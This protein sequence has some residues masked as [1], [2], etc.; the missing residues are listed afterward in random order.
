ML[1]NPAEQ[2]LHDLFRSTRGDSGLLHSG[3]RI[4]QRHSQVEECLDGGMSRHIHRLGP[5]QDRSD[6]SSAHRLSNEAE[7]AILLQKSDVA[8][9]EAEA[10]AKNMGVRFYRS[11]A[12]EGFNIT[13]RKR[14]VIPIHVCSDSAGGIAS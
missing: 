6:R 7:T 2:M 9:E 1:F 8:P 3:S 14:M 4:L 13:E 12:K 10:L 11:S 5:E